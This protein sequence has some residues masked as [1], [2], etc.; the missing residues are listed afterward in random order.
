ML[1]TYPVSIGDYWDYHNP[2][3]TNQLNQPLF[4]GFSMGLSSTIH[5]SCWGPQGD[6]PN[7]W[8]CQCV[9]PRSCSTPFR[10]S[11]VWGRR[12]WIWGC[13]QTEMSHLLSSCPLVDNLEKTPQ[14]SF[15]FEICSFLGSCLILSS[16]I[17]L[18]QG[19]AAWRYL[20]L[21]ADSAKGRYDSKHCCLS[22]R[23]ESI[24]EFGPGQFF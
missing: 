4:A 11:S 19:W 12:P 15:W 16:R 21:K 3:T 22:L 6:P 20:P 14:G 24:W 1:F 2:W 7:S 9:K 10:H 23:L 17:K 8:G 5:C 13:R 18:H